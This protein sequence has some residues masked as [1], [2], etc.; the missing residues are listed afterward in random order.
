[1]ENYEDIKS[2][3]AHLVSKGYSPKEIVSAFEEEIK[4]K[5]VSKQAIYKYI[6]EVKSKYI[7][8]VLNKYVKETT[9]P[10]K[11][12]FVLDFLIRWSEEFQKEI[13]EILN[14]PNIKRKVMALEP[15][16][17]NLERVYGL[18][19]KILPKEEK[20]ARIEKID[21]MPI[22]KIEDEEI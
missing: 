4:N 6:G 10:E 16:L 2:K 12:R 14:N 11:S 20:I 19:E 8:V 21:E 13:D 9:I 17:K 22:K 5:V 7:S 18:L 1:M 3:V 15:Y